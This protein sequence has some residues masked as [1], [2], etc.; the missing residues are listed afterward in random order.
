MTGTEWTQSSSFVFTYIH[1]KWQL[2]FANVDIVKSL[3]GHFAKNNGKI[4][5]RMRNVNYLGELKL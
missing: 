4:E 3:N 5:M 2:C 1:I